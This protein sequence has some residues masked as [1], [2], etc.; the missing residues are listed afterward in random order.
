M[1]HTAC[2]ICENNGKV[3]GCIQTDRV[4]TE[5]GWL[6]DLRMQESEVRD[7]HGNSRLQ[8]LVKYW[9]GVLDFLLVW[10]EI[11]SIFESVG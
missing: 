3:L 1:L 2:L 10:I 6:G 11:Q 4:R 7:D 8:D 5:T 9:G